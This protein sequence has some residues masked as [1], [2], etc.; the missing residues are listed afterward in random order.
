MTKINNKKEI[1]QR[2]ILYDGKWYNVVNVYRCPWYGEDKAQFY[3]D[4]ARQ[5]GLITIRFRS[6]VLG[7]IASGLA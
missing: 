1:A 7:W 6:T 3:T 2:K 4:E 5:C